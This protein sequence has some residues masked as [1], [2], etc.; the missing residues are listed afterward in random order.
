M[1][2]WRLVLQEIAHRKMNFV[3]VL[4]PVTV[5]VACLVG[6]MTLLRADTIQTNKILEAKQQEVK[7]IIA[8]KQSAVEK[9]GR[10]LQD[11]MRKIT[12]KGGFNVL[13]LS[14]DQNLNELHVQG[15][16][17]KT[18]P[19]SHVEKLANSKIVT[20]N[21]LLPMVTKRM[22]WP[23]KKIPVIII[24]TRGEVPLAHRDP[25]KPLQ[26]H[27]PRG[28]MLMG[29]QLHKQLNVLKE[30]AKEKKAKIT[31]MG[32]EFTITE[33][34][35]E[36]GTSD[37]SSVWINLA[38]A[39]ELFGMQNLLHGIFALECNCATQDRVAEIRSEIAGIL[40][41]TQVIER[42]DVATVRA[43]ARNKAK[44]V[45]LASLKRE[46]DA[47][48]LAIQREKQ[49][50]A[51]L[52]KQRE[53]V[54]AVLVPLVIGG[55]IVWIGFLIFNNV[56][57]RNEEIG[58]LRAIGFR[59]SQILFIFLGKALFVGILG[60]GVGYAT[61]FAIGAAFSNSFSGEMLSSL[62]L[63][64][65]L[66]LAVVMAPL[67]SVVAGWIPAMLAARQDPAVVLQGE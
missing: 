42:G 44:Q 23:E 3:L 66:L 24:G 10:E 26:D 16:A 40:P 60:A 39:Q 4:L 27:V 43:E 15:V 52:R 63:P 17:S 49:G 28:T 20:V 37:D 50:R 59:S 12:K 55:C 21:H 33:L 32:K 9:A 56:R 46:K 62:F 5:A 7:Q 6:T 19:E 34:Y 45:A 38:E 53:T 2:V 54:T 36:R 11:E 48:D 58:I 51:T 14:E 8:D 57:Q 29:Y 61:G 64:Q 13:I 25:K 30:D 22:V 1:N 35:D 65:I 31:L 41:G 18:I 47:G 67:L